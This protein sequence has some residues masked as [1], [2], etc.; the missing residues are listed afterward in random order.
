M[1]CRTKLAK[2]T[3]AKHLFF[4]TLASTRR[5]AFRYLPVQL[6]HI[7]TVELGN[8]KRV[9]LQSFRFSY[10]KQLLELNLRLCLLVYPEITPTLNPSPCNH[11][12]LWCPN[13]VGPMRRKAYSDDHLSAGCKY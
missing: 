6:P 4:T 5:L 10:Y 1:S 9:S 13:G 2:S 11:C 7:C 3:K 8:W 12:S